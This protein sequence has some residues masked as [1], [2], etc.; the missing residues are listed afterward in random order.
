MK[1]KKL[2]HLRR[3]LPRC[4]NPK[5]SVAFLARTAFCVLCLSG[6]A[7][8]Q[9]S[10]WGTTAQGVATEVVAIVKWVGIIVLCVAGIA[11]AADH[12]HAVFAK[13]TGVFI[14]LVMALFANPMVTWIQGLGGG[15][16]AI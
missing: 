15:G 11:I 3:V 9:T 1:F 8:A 4:Q 10:A 14:G 6:M 2:A 7:F 13:I 5:P 12:S 16:G